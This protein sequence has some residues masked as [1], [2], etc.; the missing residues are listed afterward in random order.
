MDVSITFEDVANVAT[1]VAPGYFLLVGYGLIYSRDEKGFSRLLVESIAFSL[2]IVGLYNFVWRATASPTVGPVTALRYFIPLILVSLLLG[3]VA[4]HIRQSKTFE[5][6]ATKLKIP[7]PD[8]DFIKVQFRKLKSNTPVTVT[9][10]SGEIFSGTPQGGSA[11]SKGEP[12]EY[13]FNN[14]AWYRPNSKTKRWEERP[15]SI[16]VNLETV[17]YMEI[18]DQNT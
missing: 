1:L 18:G 10:K 13:A 2:P 16:I 8:N 5:K 17:Q 3:F 11:Y 4:S 9:L 12:R 15:G 7:G 6:L 14:L